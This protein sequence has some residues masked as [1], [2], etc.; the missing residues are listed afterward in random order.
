M[1]KEEAIE[2]TLTLANNRAN[3]TD[4]EGI[5]ILQLLQKY[6]KLPEDEKDKKKLIQDVV[7]EFYLWS[8]ETVQLILESIR[9]FY[10]DDGLSAQPA[11]VFFYHEDGLTPEERIENWINYADDKADITLAASHIIVILDTESNYVTYQ[12]LKQKVIGN[13]KYE[14]WAVVQGPPGACGGCPTYGPGP[15]KDLS[16]NDLP[17]YHTEC[18]CQAIFYLQRREDV[19]L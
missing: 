7:D 3:I 2:W 9:D 8:E 17:P 10:G 4:K 15:A 19:I 12:I 1:T 14:A 13:D 18:Q 6:N 5:R 11:D 16:A